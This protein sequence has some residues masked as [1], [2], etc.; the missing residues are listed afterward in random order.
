MIRIDPIRDPDSADP[1]SDRR[2]Q[3]HDVSAVEKRHL[4]R[5]CIIQIKISTLTT[6]LVDAQYILYRKSHYPN[7]NERDLEIFRL[8][9]YSAD[10]ENIQL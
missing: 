9:K 7:S 6:S 1:N 4:R 8:R 5:F 3:L 10:L 2:L